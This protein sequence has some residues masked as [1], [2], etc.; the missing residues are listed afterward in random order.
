MPIETKR[1]GNTAVVSVSGRL[2]AVTAPQYKTTI[3][4]LV[5]SGA[6]RV[7]MDLNDLHYVSSA[8][9]AELLVAANLLQQHGGQ[10]CLANVQANVGSVF[11]MC[12]VADMLK[13]HRSVADAL[14]ALA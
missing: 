8:G 12:G 10:F 4:H 7:V 13:I 14:A 6:T 5:D 11:E 3:W 1:E 9:L 2:D